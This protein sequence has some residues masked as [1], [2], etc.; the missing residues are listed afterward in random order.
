MI[1][2]KAEIKGIAEFPQ[3]FSIV[4]MNFFSFSREGY[5]PVHGACIQ[6]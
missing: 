4:E 6:I 3:G 1:R 5:R 2:Y